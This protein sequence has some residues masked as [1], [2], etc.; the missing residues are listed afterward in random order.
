MMNKLLTG[1]RVLVVEDEMM[2]LMMMED[3]LASLGCEAVSAA[4]NVPKAAALI[5]EQSFDLALLDMNLGGVETYVLADALASKQ[6]PF[7]FATGYGNRD[8]R[9]GYQD[10]PMLKKPFSIEELA[11]VLSELLES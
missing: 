3:V 5:E 11:K 4:S 6:V 2:V 9:T 10:R 7:A 1:R 8:M